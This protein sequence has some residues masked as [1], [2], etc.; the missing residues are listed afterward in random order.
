MSERILLNGQ[1][2]NFQCRLPISSLM[3]H[4]SRYVS[5][6]SVLLTSC[7]GIGSLVSHGRLLKSCLTKFKIAGASSHSFETMQEAV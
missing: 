2:G 7:Q 5:G 3:A 4:D 6:S 1:E